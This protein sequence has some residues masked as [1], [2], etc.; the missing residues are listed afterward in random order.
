MR[1]ANGDE[2]SV[3]CMENFDPVGIHTGDSIVVAPNQTLPD[4][5]YQRLR[6]AALAIVAA[7][8]IEGAAT[9]NWPSHR[10]VMIIT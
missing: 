9:F 7:L 1:D 10:L 2:I 8:K 6:S 5:Q 3:C 4:V